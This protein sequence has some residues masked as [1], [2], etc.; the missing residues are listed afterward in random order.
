MT[1]HPGYTAATQAA[2]AQLRDPSHFQWTIVFT[3]VLVAYL[4]AGEVQAGRTRVVAAGLALWFA[5]WINELLNSAFLHLNGVAPLWV[6]TGPTAYQI[7]VGLNAETT[8]LFL[9]HGMVYAKMLPADRRTRLL[10]VDSRL[11]V[12]VAMSV[13]SVGIE[14]VL[15][16]IGVLP[17]HW[18]FWDVPWGLPFIFCFGYLWF[19][20]AAA[21]AHDAPTE[22][23]RWT[24]VGTLASVAAALGVVFGLAGWL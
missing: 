20:L 3:L 9:L 8:M 14:L 1:A 18:S 11:A 12:A 24:R 16:A 5:D 17:W 22:R 6:E 15:N 4:Y 21:W 13:F 10:G 23:M 19:F 2:L 7:L